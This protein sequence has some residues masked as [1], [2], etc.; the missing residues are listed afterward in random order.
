MLSAII[1]GFCFILMQ[2]FEFFDCGADVIDCFYYSC[3]FCTVGLH[4]SHVLVGLVALIVCLILGE[5]VMGC[6]YITLCV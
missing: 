5:E 6:Y 3:C 1:L 4:F 2:I